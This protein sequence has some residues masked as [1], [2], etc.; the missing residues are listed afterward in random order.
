M[1]E[2]NSESVFSFELQLRFQARRIRFRL[3]T[4]KGLILFLGVLTVKIVLLLTR[5]GPF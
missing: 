4:K 1:E 3:N 5:Y 2:K